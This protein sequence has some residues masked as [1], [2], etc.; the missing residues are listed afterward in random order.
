M[1]VRPRPALLAPLFMALVLH[2]VTRASGISWLALLSAAALA[3][4]VA[5][6]VVRPR[7]DHLQVVPVLPARAV[8]GDEIELE[9]RVRNGGPSATPA[10]E[11]L[12]EHPGLGPLS[13]SL[14][15]LAPGA[16]PTQPP[17]QPPALSAL[18][19]SIPALSPGQEVRLR[20]QVVAR[21]RGV[22]PSG[23]AQLGTT[24]PYG[25]LRWS[26]SC[27][28]GQQ[29]LIVH[30]A[31]NRVRDL[32]SEGSPT[33]ADRSVAVAGSGTEVLGLRP[34]RQGDAMRHLSAR[35][36]ARHGRPVV[37]ERETETGPSL[38][39]LAVGGG[40]GPAWER[41]VSTA[42][43][44]SLAALRDGRPP[45]LLADPAPTR[46]DHLGILD[47]FAGVDAAGPPTSEDLQAGLRAAGRGGTLMLLAPPGGFEHSQ[48]VRRAA[49]AAGVQ[50]LNV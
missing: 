1:T 8:A 10:C 47:F 34:W 38:V 43:S 39:V 31:V 16:P 46:L 36:S 18:A 7:L 19:A 6:L 50:V 20:L 9:V 11:W 28:G 3:L 2:L 27:P 40:R 42:A 23:V 29:P 45:V 24:A 14:P 15:A 25:L 22:H 49:A 33:A 4:P 5:S 30:P 35:A 17:A 21:A 13:G 37:L 12:L 26:R 32:P 48:A 41:S 44:L